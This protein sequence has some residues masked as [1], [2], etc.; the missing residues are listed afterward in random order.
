M[1]EKKRWEWKKDGKKGRKVGS[2][3]R[4]EREKDDDGNRW[5]EEKKGRK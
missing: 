1:K 4:E 2:K 3:G 5:K